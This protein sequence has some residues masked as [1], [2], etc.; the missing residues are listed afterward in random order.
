MF[1]SLPLPF[2]EFLPGLIGAVI[3]VTSSAVIVVRAVIFEAV[4]VA[5]FMVL[6]KNNFT[7]LLMFVK[8]IVVQE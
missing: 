1:L 8:S 6:E 3:G 7:Q 4:S 5:D 2:G